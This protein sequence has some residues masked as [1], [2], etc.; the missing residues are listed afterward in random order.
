MLGDEV[1]LARVAPP[2]EE[3]ADGSTWE[4]SA[5]GHGADAKWAIGDVSQAVPLV[6]W[7][8]HTGVVTMTYFAALRKYVLTI[9]TASFYPSM[10]HQFDTYF[11]ESDDITGP[12]AYVN[13]TTTADRTRDLHSPPLPAPCRLD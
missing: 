12:W 11:L 9:S 7:N 13:C 2:H 6:T 4:F 5:G 1:Y 3:L 10:T 8:N